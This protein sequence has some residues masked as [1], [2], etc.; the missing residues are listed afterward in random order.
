MMDV[1]EYMDIWGII[2]EFTFKNKLVNGKDFLMFLDSTLDRFWFFNN[3]SRQLLEPFLKRELQEK[4]TFLD[5]SYA[6][7]RRIP[8]NPKLYG[9]II[10]KAN[11]GVGIFPDYFHSQNNKYKAMHGYDFSR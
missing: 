4:G 6:N 8:I 5:E 11:L 10:W 7:N 9:E 3:K 2:N 1:R